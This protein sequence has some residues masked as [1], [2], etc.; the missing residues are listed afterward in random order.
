[1]ANYKWKFSRVGGI[2]RV[3][4]TSGEDIAHLYELD[5]KMWTVLS[6]PT[7]GLEIDEASL[8]Y[9]DTNHDGAIHVDE[10]I[11]VSKWLTSV[12]KD[13][14]LILEGTDTLK[15]DALNQENADG[16]ALYDA[17]VGILKSLGKA[18]AKEISLADSSSCLATV[19]KAKLEAALAAIDKSAAIEAP[20]G[21]QTDAV[22]AAYNALDAKVKDY[23]MRG[24]LAQFATES[25]A[26]LDVQVAQIQAISAENLTGKM[27]EIANYP[28]ARVEGKETLDL[29]AAINPAWAARFNVIRGIL[30]PK[31]KELTEADWAGIGSKLKAFRDYQASITIT[32][33]DIK[34]DDESAGVQLVDKL[35]H[36]TRDYYTLLKNYVTL[37]DFYGRKKAIFQ[38]GT[39]LIDQRACDLCVKVA[40]AGAIA[41]QAP[42]SGMYLVTCACSSK[43]WNESYSI[44]AAMTVGDVDDIYVG[45]NCIFYDRKGRDFEARVTSIIDNPIS[46]PQAMW[47][48][49]KKMGKMISDQITKFAAE[50]EAGVMDEAAKGI[51]E[52]SDAV[53]NTSA[54]TAKETGK[55]VSTFDIA[56]YAGIFAA[57]GM[58][59]GMLA[60]A[61]VAIISGIAKVFA[62]LVW[63]KSC[64]L[65]LAVICGII[66][67][68]S[69]PSMFLAW[70]KLRQRNL[71]PVLNANG[72][73]VN[74][75]AKINIPFGA[76]LSQAA[77][78]PKTVGAKDPFSEKMPLWKR[79]LIWL[80]IILAVVAGV[81]Y[82][83]YTKGWLDQWL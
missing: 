70:L 71:A 59:L 3:Q 44:V 66:I 31:A 65:I 25:T 24:K 56:K 21:D 46:I 79:L 8:K 7:Q 74:A 57:I 60:S 14:E 23:F 49:Y 30:D 9:M 63:W 18:D 41:A 33:A 6:C 1:M 51:N 4:V 43:V 40:D 58:A 83:A 12:L 38:A 62:G 2:T 48:P 68:I 69:G 17:A 10:V 82:Y 76:T 77:K 16:K 42:K 27:D 22:E 37:Q 67:L 61:L 29:K 52:K 5:K 11:E 45:K 35:L 50:K 81:G 64:L 73:A 39:L 13:K 26:S 36:L 72:W 19:L 34:L 75:M 32:E 78:Y 47:S 55:S 28:I 80:I 15:L 20:F 53:K 54:E